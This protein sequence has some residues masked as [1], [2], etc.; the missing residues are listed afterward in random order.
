VSAREILF[1]DVRAVGLL[2]HALV[3]RLLREGL[4]VRSLVFPLGLILGTLVVTIGVVAALRNEP[5]V[6]MPAEVATA[7]MRAALQDNDLTLLVVPDP[8]QVLSQGDAWA[9]TDGQTHWLSGSGP[10]A[11]VLESL[12]REAAH[13]S[14]RPSRQVPTPGRDAVNPMSQRIV[15]LLS[16]LF[17]LYGVVFGA[18]MV[19]RDRDDGTLEIE[20]SLGVSRWVHGAAR[21]LAGSLLLATFLALGVAMCTA[22][23]GLDDPASMLR[24]AIAS[25]VGATCIG[26]IA[27]GRAGMKAGFSGPLA[28]A[29]S[30]TTALL[31]VGLAVPMLG[32]SLPISSL[33]AGGTG[34]IPLASVAG[35]GVLTVLLF[36]RRSAVMA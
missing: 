34:W 19:A 12:L 5:V 7:E 35:L 10:A 17:D 30:A 26:L 24:H 22:I 23:M 20:L 11:L 3:R 36:T 8:E 6:A 27:A 31:G 15:I 4:V 29:M 25:A 21:L 16:I 9:A 18:G 32:R 33:I 14:W 28:F 2:S 1:A 13:A